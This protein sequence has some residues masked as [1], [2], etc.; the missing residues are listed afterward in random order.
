MKNNEFDI[1]NNADEEIIEWLSSHE[2][3]LSEKE[4]KRIFA[5]SEKKYNQKK[6]YFFLPDVSNDASVSETMNVEHYSRPKYYKAVLAASICLILTGAVITG[7]GLIGK[8]NDNIVP[9]QQDP[10]QYPSFETTTSYS[11]STF[12]TTYVTA[13]DTTVTTAT[14]VTAESTVTTFN[15]PDIYE[16][17][18][19]TQTTVSESAEDI[20]QNIP[21]SSTSTPV[22]DNEQEKIEEYRAYANQLLIEL[23]SIEKICGGNVL[24]DM[25]DSFTNE[26]GDTFARVAELYFS[27]TDELISYIKSNVTDQ[28][29]N[30]R[31]SGISSKYIDADGKIYGKITTTESGYNWL[32]KKRDI[33]NITDESFTILAEFEWYNSIKLMVINVALENGTWK[34][35]SFS[36]I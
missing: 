17:Q 26:N 32:D 23:N 31:Y 6:K 22:D 16:E 21:P 33:I 9:S 11:E 10:Y 12:S 27:N 19:T 25:N 3:P 36:S 5:M 14:E 29:F 18:S 24:F 13:S 34:I 15:D 20:K 2:N 35:D 4:T 7:F 8:L 1:L 30:Q 28:L